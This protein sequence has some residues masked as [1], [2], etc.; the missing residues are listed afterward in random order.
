M[1]LNFDEA[2]RNKANDDVEKRTKEIVINR[3]I[4][5]ARATA[6]KCDG[7]DRTGFDRGQHDGLRKQRNSHKRLLKA[8]V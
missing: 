7:D 8:V 5:D 3:F 2:R 6:D 4:G 1:Q